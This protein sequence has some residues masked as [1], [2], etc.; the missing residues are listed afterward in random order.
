MINCNSQAATLKKNEVKRLQKGPKMRRIQP[1]I[2][3]NQLRPLCVQSQP[4]QSCCG[5]SQFVSLAW[6]VRD[7]HSLFTKA[8]ENIFTKGCLTSA[9]PGEVTLWSPCLPSQFGVCQT[10]RNYLDAHKYIQQSCALGESFARVGHLSST[11]A[12]IKY[13]HFWKFQSF[14]ISYFLLY[15]N[16]TSQFWSSK[17]GTNICLDASTSMELWIFFPY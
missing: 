15:L 12:N 6:S 16:R 1:N 17:C 9:F 2:K 3:I 11:K 10:V 13:S 4:S 14:S 7:T 5:S 8:L